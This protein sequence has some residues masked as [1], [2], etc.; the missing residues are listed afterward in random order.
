MHHRLLW[1]VGLLVLVV[2]VD[3]R[4]EQ[5][6]VFMRHGEKP[7]GGYGQ[8]TCQGFNRALALQDVLVAK[9][10]RPDY[11]YAPSPTRAGARSSRPA[12]RLQPVGDW[13]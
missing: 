7:S 1:I 13:T 2:T 12:R 10:G 11:L 3:A 8:L 9:Y 6:I 5:T 4:A